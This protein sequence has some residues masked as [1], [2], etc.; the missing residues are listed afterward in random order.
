MV[1]VARQGLKARGEDDSTLSELDRRIDEGT[2]PSEE[3]LREF[4]SGGFPRLLKITRL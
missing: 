4:R 3:L 2:S 1:D